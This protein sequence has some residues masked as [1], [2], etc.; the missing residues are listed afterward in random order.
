MPT[1]TA[2]KMPQAAATATSRLRALAG[3]SLIERFMGIDPTPSQ[4]P[5]EHAGPELDDGDDIEQHHQR[6]ERECDRDRA[7]ASPALL[8][9]GEH[10]PG[11]GGRIV[12]GAHPIVIPPGGSRPVGST[13]S[14]AN[15]TNRYRI[16]KANSRLAARSSP[17][18]SRTR[19]CNANKII[20]P[21]PAIATAP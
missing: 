14:I 6:P 17:A 12:H 18:P 11:L 4:R 20:M 13:S 19:S 10:D 3:S 21:P 1:M 9:F 2:T 5:V 15:S 8:L 16:E 7:R